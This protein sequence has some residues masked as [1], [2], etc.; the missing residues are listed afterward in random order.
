MSCVTPRPLFACRLPATWG[1]AKNWH[2]TGMH[3]A[4]RAPAALFLWLSGC[5][6]HSSPTLKLLGMAHRSPGPHLLPVPGAGTCRKADGWHIALAPHA[7]FNR[8]RL[9]AAR[10][11]TARTRIR[12]APEAHPGEGSRLCMRHPRE[13]TSHS[14]RLPAGQVDQGRHLPVCACAARWGMYGKHA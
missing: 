14:D 10:H 8:K 13:R 7:V 2:L 5:H 4:S 11:H 12:T 6:P 1:M 3:C 9:I